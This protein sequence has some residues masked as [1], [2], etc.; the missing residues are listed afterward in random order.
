MDSAHKFFS[1][2]EKHKAVHTIDTLVS[3]GTSRRKA[4]N[5]MGILPLYYRYWKQVVS[6]VD[7][8]KAEDVFRSFKTNGTTR[9]I[10]PGHGGLLVPAQEQLSAFVFHLHEQGIQCNNRMVAR[11]AARLVP[12]FEQNSSTVQV[13]IVRVALRNILD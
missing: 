13:Q 2:K 12:A 11:E 7:E 5:A 9:K 6:K 10:R 1:L 8:L 4:C 3:H